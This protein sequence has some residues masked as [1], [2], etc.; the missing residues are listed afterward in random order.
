MF[1]VFIAEDEDRVR[2]QIREVLEKE[3]SRYN[4]C[5][6]AADGELALPIIQELE[7]DILITDICMPFMDGL[8]L[9][10]IVKSAMPWVHILILSGFDEFEY[11]QKAID[12]G[13]AGYVLKPLDKTKLLASL[14]KIA[15]RI[16]EDRA[17]FLQT[18]S[19]KQREEQEKSR[20]IQHYF[21]EVIAGTVEASEMY[22]RADELGVN[23]I[24]PYYVLCQV[25]LEGKKDHSETRN[26]LKTIVDD[27][28]DV[29]GFNYGDCYLLLI[30]G[31]DPEQTI[32]LACSVAQQVKNG[33]QRILQE[34]ISVNI[35][36][37]INRF[38]KI[39]E[40]YRQLKKG[41]DELNKSES[42]SLIRIIAQKEENTAPLDLSLS[43]PLAEK[44][45]HMDTQ[46]IDTLIDNYLGITNDAKHDSIL[47][48]YY[49]LVDLI[50]TSV[51]MIR[52]LGLEDE[53]DALSEELNNN[54]RLL[55]YSESYK[56][57]CACARRIL[58][59]VM[60]IRD[61]GGGV[62]HHEEIKKA[63]EYIMEN[64]ADEGLSLHTVAKHVGF[65]PNHF[66]TVFSQQMGVTFIEYLIQYRIER[67]K[68]MLE[69]TEMKLTDIT[70]NIGYSEPR[71]FSYVFKKYTG[72]SPRAYRK[73]FRQ[74]NA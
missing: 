42:S 23:I 31:P 11:A 73:S 54:L 30:K 16:E 35:G 69:D 12:I 43:A 3:G 24:S 72:M 74:A 59:K 66:S 7:P 71:Y 47:Y 58:E 51:R 13:V 50:V 55:E 60:S 5:G 25:P 61:A 68:K 41:A 19:N 40:S 64:Y 27:M 34:Q 62:P 67:S 37:P 53:A 20:I 6:E 10:S 1:K 26:F 36:S 38:S 63:R 57:A 21:Y 45:R 18:L 49:L 15:S 52:E 17:E 46:D 28:E 29:I 70:F 56:E 44:L 32:D 9:S 14:E 4:V 2:E 39:S 22:D 8:K 48:R 65:S 33:A